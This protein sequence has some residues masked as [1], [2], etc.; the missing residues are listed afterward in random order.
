M[1]HF[2]EMT[3]FLYLDGQLER[4]QASEV[5]THTGEC[6]ECRMLLESLKRETLWIEQS[7]QEKDPVPARFAAPSKH[8]NLR[9]G[10][11][12]ALAMAI[13]GVLTL[14]NGVVEPFEHQLNQAGFSGGNLMTMLFFSGAFWKGWSSLLTFF[15]FFAGTIFCILALVFLRRFW[16]GGTVIGVVLANAGFLAL[17]LLMVMAPTAHAGEVVHGHPSY[18]LPSGQTVNNDLFVYGDFIRIDGTVNGDVFAWGREVE[19]TGHVTGDVIAA[20]SELHISGQVEGNVRAWVQTFNVTG[21]VNK[22][23]LGGCQDFEMDRSAKIGGTLTLFAATA[24]ISG[25]VARDLTAKLGD[26]TIDGSIGGG[27]KVSG[28]DLRIGPSASVRGRTEYT[29]RHEATVD[30]GAKLA[31]PLAFTPLR[32]GPTYSSWRY[33]WHRAEFW[34]AAF[35]FGLVLLLLVPQFFGD[36]VRASKNVLP[37]LGFGVLFLFATPIVAAIVCI[38]VVG[39]G[40]SIPTILIWLVAIYAAQ[41]FVASWLGEILLGPTVGTGGLLGRLALGLAIIHGLEI[42]PYHVG[43]LAHLVV[44]WWGLG[45]IAMAVYRHLKRTSIVAPP[46]VA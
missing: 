40:I 46:V 13:A 22:N 4:A 28:E 34:G 3:A 12:T 15:G 45:A 30:P 9:W 11:A 37:S 17:L 36:V 14:W 16:R 44:L 26:A 43:F 29:G 7:L 27:L 8:P 2:D 21:T 1:N 41:V 38:T 25:N 33:Y 5:L 39:I 20:A 42:I 32:E 23:L 24:M 31:S 6:A 10:W 19:I 35:L 18:T